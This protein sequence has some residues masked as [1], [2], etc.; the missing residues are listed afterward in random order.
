MTTYL[1]KTMLA[2]LLTMASSNIVHGA[3]VDAEVP[4]T[5]INKLKSARSDLTYTYIGDAPI[6][7]F[8][9]V[10]IEDG[11]IIYVSSD[12]D[13]FLRWYSLSN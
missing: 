6:A 5:I 2:L 7:S 13:F 12:G 4:E 3:S 11:P 9:E 1:K 8:H 10:Q